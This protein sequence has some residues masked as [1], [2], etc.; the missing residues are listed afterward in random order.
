MY[1]NTGAP[2]WRRNGVFAAPLLTPGMLL[3]GSLVLFPHPVN[4]IM[5]APTFAFVLAAF[6]ASYR[7]PAPFLPAWIRDEIDRGITPV[8]RPTGSDWF[9]FAMIVPIFGLTIVFAPLYSVMF[10]N[11]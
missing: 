5:V 4:Q 3:F 2:I 8:A 1:S 9:V 10:P 7:V 6:V 11:G